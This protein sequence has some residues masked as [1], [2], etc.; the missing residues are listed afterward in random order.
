MHEPTRPS[1]CAGTEVS[2]TPDEVEA[3]I[4]N[5]TGIMELYLGRVNGT[6]LEMATDAVL[7]TSTAK[8]VTAGHRLYG[9]VDGDL[10]FAFDMAAVGQELQPHLWG[11][12][13]R[14]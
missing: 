8:E 5:P 9:L 12:L 3:L 4:T 13:V 10:W 2:V 1:R 6:Q 7:R 11:R 14:Q